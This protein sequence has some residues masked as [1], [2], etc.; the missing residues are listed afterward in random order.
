[1]SWDGDLKDWDRGMHVLV[2][3]EK[4]GG[5]SR[6]QARL[7]LIFHYSIGEPRAENASIIK[8]YPD[9]TTHIE[10]VWPRQ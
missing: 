1:M 7:R 4:Y 10:T 8:V 6:A 2:G 9:A 3:E 5:S